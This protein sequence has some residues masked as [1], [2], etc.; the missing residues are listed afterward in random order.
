MESSRAVVRSR[1]KAE[2][3]HLVPVLSKRTTGPQDAAVVGNRREYEDCNLHVIDL[4]TIS[5]GTRKSPQTP[6]LAIP[7]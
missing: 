5:S 7:S 6:V 2:K 1:L 3:M 4:A